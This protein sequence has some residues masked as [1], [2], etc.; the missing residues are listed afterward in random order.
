MAVAPCEAVKPVPYAVRVRRKLLVVVG[1]VGL[2]VGGYFGYRWWKGGDEPVTY[3]TQPAGRGDVI[4]AVTASGTLSPLV[5]VDVGSQVS[6]RIQ[7]LLVD[8]NDRVTAGQ[9]IARI[10]PETTLAAVTQAK[11]RLTAARADF[12]RAKATAANAKLEYTRAQELARLGAISQSE[13]DA[14]QLTASSAASSVTGSSSQIVEA[15]ASLAQAQTNLTYTTI[16]SPIDGI[17]ISRAVNVGQTVAASLSAPTLFTIAEDL[18]KMEVHTSVS[19]SDVGQLVEGMR[20]E[21]TVDAFPEDLFDGVVR[22]VRFEA[23]TVQNVVTY[24]AVVEVDNDKLKLRPGMT[25]NVTF[26]AAEAKDVLT[27]ATKALRYRPAGAEAGWRDG[28]SGSGAGSASGSGEWSGRR[29]ERGER[30]GRRGSGGGRGNGGGRGDGG[31]SGGGGGGGS[32]SGAGSAIAD[33]GGSGAGSGS[34]GGSAIADGSGGNAGAPDADASRRRRRSQAVWV[35]R[36]GAPVR[37]RVETGLSDGTTTEITGGDLA[38]GDLV[39][40]SDS[41]TKTTAAGGS[42]RPSQPFG[43]GSTRGGRRGGGF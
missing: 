42:N 24:D 2:G 41:S 21:F 14:A 16:K 38:E 5:K 9:V 1:L 27:V 3:T 35:L 7:E 12:A 29:G 19:E 28:G 43:G 17:V 18:R 39:I 20:V 10:D 11:A 25:A 30:G 22:Q 37:V 36:A 34:G 32:G 13:L 31:G 15:Q 4:Q 33:G 8:Y 26:I 40:V 6:G 23:T